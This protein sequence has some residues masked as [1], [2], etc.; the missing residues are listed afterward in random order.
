MTCYMMEIFSFFQNVIISLMGKEMKMGLFE[1][2]NKYPAW[3]Y[4]AVPT[5][6]CN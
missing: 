2:I 6:I 5:E 1:F 3:C 4:T